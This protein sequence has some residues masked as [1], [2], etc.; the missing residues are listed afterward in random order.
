MAE[1]TLKQVAEFFRQPGE[2]LS[3]FAEE[4]KALSDTDKEQIKQG[5][6]DGSFSY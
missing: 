5:I 3:K 2:T 4:W 1:A 6:G